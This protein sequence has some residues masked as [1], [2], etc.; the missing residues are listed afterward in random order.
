MIFHAA[1][2]RTLANYSPPVAFPAPKKPVAPVSKRRSLQP[3]R[4]RLLEL[5][6]VGAVTVVRFR[7]SHILTPDVE[8][9]SQELFNL[10]ESGGHHQ[11]LLDFAHIERLTSALLGKLIILHQKCRAHRGRLV[12]CRIAPHLMEIFTILNLTR[13]LEVFARPTEAF[14][15][16]HHRVKGQ[17]GVARTGWN[18]W[19]LPWQR[20][21]EELN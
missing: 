14:Q 7:R 18:I 6:C 3:I 16:F 12:L 21:E 5:E 4:Q 9:V 20:P 1:R 2:P 8:A 19:R 15:A 17:P 13:V 10:V 11:V